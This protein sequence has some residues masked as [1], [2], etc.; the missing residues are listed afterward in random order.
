MQ[1]VVVAGE[2]G[3]LLKMNLN[4]QITRWAAVD[5]VLAFA[6]QPYAI[7]LINP[8]RNLDGQRL[9]LLDPP[10]AAAALAGLG[11][12][13]A[14]AMTLRAGLLDREEALLQTNLTGAAAGRTGLRLRARLCPGA[15]TRFADFHGWNA[16]LRFRAV[17]SLFQRDFQVVAKIGTTVDVGATATA[18]AT[19]PAENFVK[20]T[21]EGVG[22]TRS[23]TEAG[24]THAGLL[25]DTGMTILVVGGAFLTVRQDLVSFLDFLELFFGPRGVG[26]AVRVMLH[27]QLAVGL[28]DFFFTGVAVDAENFVKVAF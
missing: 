24:A 18:T 25:I 23:A 7:A 17:G 22:K 28:L 8:G 11:N 10:G 21:A 1:I 5:A 19:T 20:D 4:V 12:V 15:M 2:Y 13:T 6:G 14:G 3:V 26:V 9:V 16:D 27:G